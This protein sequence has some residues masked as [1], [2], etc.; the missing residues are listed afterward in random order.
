MSR[1]EVV[2]VFMGRWR[3]LPSG[4]AAQPVDLPVDSA[5]RIAFYRQ[6]VNKSPSEI[7]AY[8][9]RLIFSG[10]ARPPVSPDSREEQI[11]ILSLTQGAIGYLERSMVDGRVK[12]VF[13]F[14]PPSP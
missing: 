5:E 6:L 11:Q 8:W 12:I 1:E 9:S 14:S 3:Q 4:I 13:E 2:F 10:G 7:K